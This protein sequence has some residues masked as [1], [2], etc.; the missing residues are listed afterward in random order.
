MGQLQ[1]QTP[2]SRKPFDP[3]L[4]VTLPLAAAFITFIVGA[5]SMGEPF[6]MFEWDDAVVFFGAPVVIAVLG[7]IW[8]CVALK[9]RGQRRWFL[10][11]FGIL[12]FAWLTWVAAGEMQMYLN[13]PWNW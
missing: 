11:V 7:V 6:G 8:V 3:A 13:E 10:L 2:R 12:Y 9:K 1:Y 5:V 4:L